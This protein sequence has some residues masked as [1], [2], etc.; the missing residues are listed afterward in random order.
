VAKRILICVA[1]VAVGL[2]AGL[3][4]ATGDSCEDWQERSATAG[5][6]AANGAISKAEYYLIRSDRPKG[7]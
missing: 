1:C 6:Q 4:F 2:A 3:Y 5:I 7:C